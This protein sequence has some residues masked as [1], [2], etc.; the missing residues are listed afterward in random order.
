MTRVVFLGPPGAG[1]GTQAAALSVRIGIP[2]LSTGEMLRG[3]AANGTTLGRE[4]DRYMKAGQLVPDELVLGVLKAR[5][6]ERDAKDGFI[7]DGFPRTAAQAGALE[8][9]APIDR[10][11]FFDLPER[12]LLERLTGRRNC[13]KCGTIYNVT[14]DPPKDDEKCDRDGTPLIRRSD[15]AEE[16]VR[17]RLSVYAQKTAPLLEHYRERGLLITLDARGSRDEV[18]A[19]IDAA[20]P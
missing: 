10:V 8:E 19:R 17:T 20:L 9:M 16:A 2:H 15:D 6:V 14:T 4:A 5:I 1:K 13:P 3:A 12:L 11:L 18:G 7:L